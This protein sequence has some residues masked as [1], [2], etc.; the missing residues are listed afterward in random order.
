MIR[1]AQPKA[2]KSALRMFL[3]CGGEFMYPVEMRRARP[4]YVNTGNT[5]CVLHLK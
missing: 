4:N 5:C 2:L 1:T 3:R